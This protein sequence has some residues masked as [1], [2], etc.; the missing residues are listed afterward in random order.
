MEKKYFDKMENEIGLSLSDLI[1]SFKEKG[2]C[3][4]LSQEDWFYAETK[5][6]RVVLIKNGV[7]GSDVLKD[8]TK[9]CLWFARQDGFDKWSNSRVFILNLKSKKDLEDWHFTLGFAHTNLKLQMPDYHKEFNHDIPGYPIV[10]N[11]W[12]RK[13]KKEQNKNENKDFHA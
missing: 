3:T 8:G 6:F 9:Y 13:A 2:F 7:T 1:S 10:L 11:S 12:K 4:D 5:Y